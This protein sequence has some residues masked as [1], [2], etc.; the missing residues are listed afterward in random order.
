MSSTPTPVADLTVADFTVREDGVLR[1]VLRVS[2]AT[3]PMQVALLVD[4]SFA[5]R[6]Y[7]RDLRAGLGV[8]VERLGGAH[9]VAVI[10][11][12]ERPSGTVLAGGRRI[13]LLRG[14]RFRETMEAIADELL[15]QYLRIYARP[16]MLVAPERAELGTTREALTVR[17]RAVR[18]VR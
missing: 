15:S 18:E 16:E 1:E 11:F 4:N 8:F 3:D 17:G 6:S 10:T 9:E 12:A 7:L 13:D 5:T 2:P 14:Q